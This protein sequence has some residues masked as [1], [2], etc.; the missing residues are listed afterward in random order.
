MERMPRLVPIDQP[1]SSSSRNRG[2]AN[3]SIVI[4]DATR[5]TWRTITIQQCIQNSGL[6]NYWHP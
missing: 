1:A 2:W 4:H 3:R 5:D 6:F